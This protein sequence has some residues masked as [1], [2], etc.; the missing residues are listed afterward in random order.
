MYP[1]RPSH[2]A[3]KHTL[4]QA[5]HHVA[6]VHDMVQLVLEEV[7]LVL[8]HHLRATPS[9][10]N[11]HWGR[12]G[13]TASQSNRLGRAH[14]LNGLAGPLLAGRQGA[15]RLGQLAAPVDEEGQPW[16][17]RKELGVGKADQQSDMRGWVVTR[18][19]RIS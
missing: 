7:D 1:W 11:S 8:E 19:I 15:V 3:Y 14:V 16:G 4:R 13:G 17:K 9:L 10:A 2:S 18:K 5:L 12:G 6:R